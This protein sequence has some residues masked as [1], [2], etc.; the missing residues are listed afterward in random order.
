M[1][2]LNSDA[3]EKL[4]KLFEQMN[5][6]RWQLKPI[7]TEIA[8]S[9]EKGMFIDADSDEVH[10]LLKQILGA[11]Q[12]FFSVEQMKAA[13]SSKK[14]D[15]L[16]K[17][18]ITLEQNCKLEKITKILDRISTL[19]VDSES[20]NILDAVKKVQDKAEELKSR[21][22]STEPNHLASLAKK[23]VLLTEVIENASK[24]EELSEEDFLKIHDN[25]SDTPL[26]TMAVMRRILH[27]KKPKAQPQKPKP[28]EVKEKIPAPQVPNTPPV[29]NKR[30]V[31]DVLKKLEKAVPKPDLSLALIERKNFTIEE[32]PDNKKTSVKAFRNKIRE[33]LGNSDSNALV[34]LLINTRI[35]FRED[36]SGIFSG[37]KFNKKI[38]DFN[39]FCEKL[40]NWGIVDKVTWRGMEFYFL[41]DFGVELCFRH[42]K[43]TP[44]KSSGRYYFVAMVESLKISMLAHYEMRLRNSL[45]VR[46]PYGS[47]VPFARANF[48]DETEKSGVVLIFSLILLGESWA[49]HSASF[50]LIVEQELE[51][52]TDLKAVIILALSKDDIAWLKIFETIKLKKVKFLV[53][54]WDG[55]LDKDGNQIDLGTLDEFFNPRE[56]IAPPAD[57]QTVTID[58]GDGSEDIFSNPPETETGVTEIKFKPSVIVE[59]PV[60]T[61]TTPEDIFRADSLK[62]VTKLFR[63]GETGRGMLALHSLEDLFADNENEIWI[64][65]LAREIGFILDDPVTL[66]ALHDFDT[67]S[68]WTSGIEVPKINIGADYLNL[69]AAIKNFYAPINPASYQIQQLWK[70]LNGDKSNF[71]LKEF[72]A[73]KKLASIFNIFAENNGL[74]FA[75]CLQ[76]S[77]DNSESNLNA[78]RAQLEETAQKIDSFLIKRYSLKEEVQQVFKNGGEVRKFLSV[79]AYSP[80]EILEFCQQ[81]TDADLNQLVR[82]SS[83][84]VDEKIFSEKKIENYIEKI[85]GRT[86]VKSI[87]R[88]REGFNDKINRTM[89][90]QLMAKILAALTDYVHARKK[91][92]ASGSGAKPSAP[93]DKALEILDELKSQLPAVSDR[94]TLGQIIFRAF[95]EN[96]GRK[97]RG[98]NTLLSYRACLLGSKYIELENDLPVT[99][100]FGVEEFSLRNRVENFEAELD[101]KSFAENLQNAYDTAIQNYDF[102][103]WQCLSRHFKQQSKLTDE[104]SFERSVERQIQRTYDNFLNDLELARTYSRITDQKK[105]DEYSKVVAA[106][107]E[108]FAYTKNAGL[109]QRFIAA[110]NKAIDD[111]SQTQSSALTERLGKLEENLRSNLNEGETL[112]TRYKLIS[113]VRH[114]IALRNFTVAEDYMNR[115]EREGGSLLTNLDLMDSD[116]ATL[117]DFIDKYE[118]L[119][120]DIINARGSV[121]GAYM[122]RKHI[123]SGRGVN[124]ETQDALAFARGWQGIHSGQNNAIEFSIIEILKHL[125]YDGKISAQNVNDLN[126][127]SYT[128]S[129]SSPI[130]A[131]T[132]YPHPFTVFGTE[133]FS[134]GLEIIYLG[135]NRSPDNIAKV[136]SDMTMADRGK[137]CLIDS[138]LPLP[139]RRKLAKAFKLDVNLKNILVIDQV[140]ALYLTQFDDAN[141]GKRMLQAAL[142]FARVQPYTSRGVLAPEMFIGRSEELDKIRDMTGPVFVYGGR[143]LGKSALLRQVKNLEHN[144]ALLSYAFFIDLKDLDSTRA[145]QRI[146][147]ELQGAKLIGQVESWEDFSLEMHK[148]LSGQLRGVE[149]PK[150]LILLLD[151][152]DAF[153]SD[154]DTENAI[155]VF[156]RL[157][158]EFSG[159]FKFVLAGLH[160]VIR[161]EK[162]S[163]FGNLNHISVL[164]FRTPDAMELFLKPMSYLGFQVEDESLISAILSHTNYYP[165]LIQYYCQMLV[166]SVKTNYQNRNFDATKNP[167]YMLDNNYLKNM[168]GNGDFQKEIK[169]RFQDTLAVVDDNYYEIL[170]LA[171]AWICYEHDDRPVSV[172]LM[173]IR[174]VCFG[175]EKITRLSDENLLGMLDEMVS[176]NL[177]RRVGD[178][179]EFNRYSFRHMLGTAVEV[180]E[181]LDS[182]VAKAEGGAS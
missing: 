26:I 163:S 13:A 131:R 126:R 129:F 152:S 73:A 175:I 47:L 156:R 89:L 76:G 68:F 119:F 3:L 14:L 127:K 56:K 94:T 172:D 64:E 74:A 108:H 154:D 137:I 7:L 111:A 81:F 139:D 6:S 5:D 164:P 178:K 120:H 67:H 124:R 72:P 16:D 151:E 53:F 28:N 100:S 62:A 109:F 147:L 132:S 63:E 79:D 142:P 133:I 113:E 46:F 176:L 61:P 99:N 118:V 168:L 107:R 158:V 121:E 39:A 19:A 48:F 138:A 117:E 69:A 143:Q 41:N 35:F 114:Q 144:P 150:K 182:F 125:G 171:V 54:T 20:P 45:K 22:G 60:E 170:A 106:A 65:D 169:Q 149:E 95:V 49:I 115:I 153:L 159:K 30:T 11:Q 160:K 4:R 36:P 10:Q 110:C 83:A 112:E 59:P 80:E 85:G 122:Q 55:L 9:I 42:L 38:P 103:I 116:L 40:F 180:G 128:V 181:K 25:F 88:D 71:A 44:P 167:P 15:V 21:A 123:S 51:A 37:G 50:R 90:V 43:R 174:D 52:G 57:E 98:E 27:F 92:D 134:K 24:S 70:Q 33:T 157:F 179:F 77:G 161:F 155:N 166:E 136:L 91:F 135:A 17:R 102:G 96:L 23:F 2:N 1:E 105:I 146:V 66:N 82:D 101:G 130:H 8:S 86:L 148:L 58:T 75:D 32:A 177:F 162:N 145:L 141:R 104:D 93:V 97:L 140:M 84:N 165:G 78:A 34:E 87:L 12:E 173:Q 29:P 18:L 31:T